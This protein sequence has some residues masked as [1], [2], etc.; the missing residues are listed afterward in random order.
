MDQ[1]SLSAVVLNRGQTFMILD[2]SGEVAHGEQGLYAGDRRL[3]SRYVWRVGHRRPLLLSGRALGPE[4]A[5]FF[6]AAP[7]YAHDGRAEVVLE[8]RLRL[9]DGA[10]SDDLRLRNYGPKH[11]RIWL[12]LDFA[13]DFAHVFHVKRNALGDAGGESAHPVPATLRDD[14]TVAFRAGAEQGGLEVRVRL[15]RPFADR[16]QTGHS[17]AVRVDLPARGQAELSLAAHSVPA[18]EPA[19]P[20]TPP[21][22]APPRPRL[23]AG[24]VLGPA[25]AAAFRR[26]LQDLEALSIRGGAIGLPR[27][28][29]H[30]AYAA[31][32]PWYIAL[33]GRD[34][35]LTSRMSVFCLP[36]QGEGSL[37]ALAALQGRA[38]D[39]VSAEEPGKILHE[40]R[41]SP[42]P[43]APRLIPRFPYYG[44][45]DATPLFIIALEELVRAGARPDLARDLAP[46]LQQAIAWIEASV[47]ERGYL[48]YSAQ[49]GEGLVNQ[50]WK[51]SWDAVH[52]PD[53]RL[54]GGPIALVEVQG[55]LYR[56][57]RV[58]ARLLRA[59]GDDGGAERQERRALLLRRRVD[60]DFWLERGCYALALDGQNRPVD[61][62]TS[63]S[64]HLL[65]TG[66]AG[67][68]RA[69]ELARSLLGS[70]LWSGRG[71]RTLAAGEGRYNPVSYHN[72]S[73]WPHDNALI[74]EGLRRTGHPRQAMAIVE[75]LL[76]VA[77]SR[78]ERRLPELFAGFGREESSEPV[79]YP[80]AC[81]VQAWSA[82]VM[83]HLVTIL[84]GLVV[85][86]SEVRLRPALPPGIDRLEVEGLLVAG[87]R[88]DVRVVRDRRGLHCEASG[89]LGLPVR[90]V[91]GAR[92]AAE[93]DGA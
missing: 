75:A 85:A 39:P 49:D 73:I 32:I 66:I 40:Y 78:P 82:A 91:R 1:G 13:S 44:S 69:A 16:P 56:A 92:P 25:F 29:P 31:G 84:L 26:S 90:V 50:G 79:R 20:R 46:H 48:R 51:D 7:E 38:R 27:Q 77:R 61:V 45:V 54:A 80:S 52:F 24:G 81:P 30:V 55:Y 65:W 15:S 86:G 23:D 12:Q 64:L 35:L 3:C 33:F 93:G 63:N 47:D 8:R 18:A 4:E 70:A 28:D 9:G 41:P 19:R 53:G 5:Q 67:R 21:P 68:R 87:G 59:M 36:R 62:L 11:R 83:P 72:G 22:D 89:E 42:G 2:A 6:L 14:R 10:F 34:A 71:V 37:R 17:L 57:R 74:A 76:R 58:A 43:D 60:Q 88:L